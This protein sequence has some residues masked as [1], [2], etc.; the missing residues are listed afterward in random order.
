MSKVKEE[1]TEEPQ[2]LCSFCEA[3]VSEPG[4]VVKDGKV[5]ACPHIDMILQPGTLRF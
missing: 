5:M 2:G 3:P 4:H 1:T